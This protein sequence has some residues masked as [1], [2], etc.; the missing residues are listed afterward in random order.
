MTGTE[1]ALPGL[2]VHDRRKQSAIRLE[3]AS[4]HD[5]LLEGTGFEPVWGFSC[6]AV[7]FGLLPV[8]CS[9]RESCS[10]SRRLRSALLHG[11]AN[12]SRYPQP[13]V[14][15]AIRM[16][17]GRPNSNMRFMTCTATVTSVA[18]RSSFRTRS[19]SPITRLY[20][21]MVAS[22]RLRLL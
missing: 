18:R 17:S 22:T 19:P 12:G 14:N 2:S 3:I 16:E 10:S 9:E 6:Q 21:P 1:R 8:L 15:Y 5:S 11:L 20:R 7:V 4:S 13:S